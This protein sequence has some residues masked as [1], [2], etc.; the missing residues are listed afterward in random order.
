M[1]DVSATERGQRFFQVMKEKQAE[2]AIS[3]MRKNPDINWKNFT[4]ADIHA[5]KYMLGETW[6]YMNSKTWGQCPFNSLTYSDLEAIVRIGAE[7]ERKEID[8]RSAAMRV[9]SIMKQDL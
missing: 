9:A 8:G 6:V 2:S 1:P 4:P 5:L 7:L 3:R